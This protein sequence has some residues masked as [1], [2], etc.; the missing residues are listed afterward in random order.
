MPE[1]KA[2]QRFG[3]YRLVKRLG[4]APTSWAE[5]RRSIPGDVLDGLM[6]AGPDNAEKLASAVADA[7][8]A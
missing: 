1:L 5:F 8:S 4:R 7:G 2:G 6:I 3:Q